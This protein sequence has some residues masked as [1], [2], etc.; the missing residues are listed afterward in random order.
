MNAVVYLRVS[1]D[2]QAQDNKYGLSS[3]WED[4]S[5]YA[6][7]NN[8]NI[9]ETYTEA[10][11]SGSLINRPMLN[12]LLKDA[13]QKKFNKVIVAKLDR[14]ARDLFCQLWV[15]KEL[16]KNNINIISVSE[17]FDDNDYMSKAF[18]QMVGVF[19]ELEKNRISERMTSGR[20][21][22]AKKGGY[23][24]G[25]V[26]IGYISDKNTNT[27]VVNLQ[28]VEAIK[29][30]FK[31]RA[32]GMSFQQIADFLNEAGHT[33]ALNKEFSK[34]QIKRIYDRKNLY[35]GNCKYSNIEAI[36]LHQAII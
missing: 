26:P 36:G 3:Q 34:N 25:R 18:R 22:K 17:P 7:Q 21:Q 30:V 35:S 19:A 33:S 31:L 4:V 32:L 16:L 1:T 9:V 27:L 5:N 11:V 2:G 12:K 10:G 23:A 28:K 8:I 13:E 15:E 14:V 24:G 29:L 6:K 20:L